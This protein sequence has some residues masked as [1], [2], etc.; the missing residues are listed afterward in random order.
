MAG[1]IG[2]FRR[3][4]IECMGHGEIA[5]VNKR[6]AKVPP[7]LNNTRPGAVT[8]PDDENVAQRERDLSVLYPICNLSI[9]IMAYRE[10]PSFIYG[11]C[12]RREGRLSLPTSLESRKSVQPVSC[13][14]TLL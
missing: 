5:E 14:L 11:R 4:D 9:L 8:M 3:H 12:E 2:A 10:G 6:G 13:R 7:T 1:R